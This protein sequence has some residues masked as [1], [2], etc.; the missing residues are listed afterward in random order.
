M[1]KK[2]VG[3]HNAQKVQKAMQEELEKEALVR[4]DHH[5]GLVDCKSLQD[6]TQIKAEVLGAIK[7]LF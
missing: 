6:L 3:G 4:I 2:M 5:I 7:K 1:Q